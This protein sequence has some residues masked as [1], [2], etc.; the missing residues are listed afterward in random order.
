MKKVLF[1]VL[2]IIILIISV[3]PVTAF[4][5]DDPELM[6]STEYNKKNQT[7]TVYYRVLNLAGTESADFRLRYN[8]DV[9][10]YVSHKEAKMSNVIMEIGNIAEQKDTIAIQFVDLYYVEPE[11]CE[12][13]GSATIVTFT[14]NVIDEKAT[15]TVFIAFTDSY[16]MDPQSTEVFPERATLKI[17]LNEKVKSDAQADDAEIPAADVEV[18]RNSTHDEYDFPETNNTIT[19]III[20]AVVC[21]VVLVG[22]TIVIVVKYRKK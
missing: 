17:P 13:D 10:E 14:F 2:A 8:P 12:E 22:G 19:K 18:D 16:A 6:L 7:I 21:A 1:S 4:A 20:A 3:L 9:V 5:W 11:D 15:E